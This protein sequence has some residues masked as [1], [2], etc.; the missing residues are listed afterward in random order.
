MAGHEASMKKGA[1]MSEQA[2]KDLLIEELQD[3]YSAE[4]QILGA[5]PKMAEAA[6]SQ[7]LKQAFQT[8]HQE[9]QGQVQR[10]EQIFQKLNAQPGGNT[11][12]ATQGLIEEAEELIGGGHP[13]EVLD[14]ALVMSAQKVEHYEIASY[15]SLRA[16]AQTC[17]MTEIAQLLEQT[18]DE[19]KA[20]DEK[21]NK[22]AEGEINAKA[23][24]AA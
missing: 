18:L 15:G 8:H 14:V 2:L 7:Q 16:L 21:L 11:C 1:T 12:E 10:L 4:T 3:T 23:L 6:S 22:I 24:K 9:T 20:T 5:L 17:G 13:P 19:E